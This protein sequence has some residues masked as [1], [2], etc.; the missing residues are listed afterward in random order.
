MEVSWPLEAPRMMDGGDAV[1][2]ISR[3]SRAASARDSGVTARMVLLLNPSRNT[4]ALLAGD[5]DCLLDRHSVDCICDRGR[6]EWR[7]WRSEKSESIAMV[8]HALATANQM[9]ARL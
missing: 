7:L 4:G 8:A 3:V 6:P 2:V 5:V 1:N 9:P